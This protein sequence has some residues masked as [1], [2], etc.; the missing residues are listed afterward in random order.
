MR[1]QENTWCLTKRPFVDLNGKEFT[2]KDGPFLFTKFLSLNAIEIEYLDEKYQVQVQALEHFK[3]ALYIHD[4]EPYIIFKC[5]TG[6][7]AYGTNLPTSDKDF[8]GV[9][10]LP[11]DYIHAVDFDPDWEEVKV[12]NPKKNEET[13]YYEIRKLLRMLEEN[14][15]NTLEIFNL[16]PECIVYK[17]P[18]FDF[19]LNCEK[20]FITKQC[21]NRFLGYANE[22]IGKAR[23]QDKKQ[24][25]EKSR[26]ERKTVLDFCYTFAGAGTVPIKTW[27]QENKFKQEHCAL[28]KMEHMSFMYAVYYDWA[29]TL[30]YRGIVSNEETAN[31]V[32]EL[33]STPLGAEP[34]CYIQFN[35]NGYSHHCKEYKSYQTWIKER[36]TQRWV[37]VKS[38]D[39][40]IDGKNMLHCVRL[41][42]MA[43][44]IAEG[45]GI[46]VRRPEAEYLKS[47]RR[48]DV[49]LDDLI[50]W[51][52]DKLAALKDKFDKSDLPE[53]VGPYVS[54]VIYDHL[55]ENLE[56][57]TKS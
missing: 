56:W 14:N 11:P 41:I 32:S 4:I 51:S 23:G 30:G 52:S 33:S 46:V 10:V 7:N 5:V 31:G 37:D 45:R 27:I 44:D 9:Y 47:I 55:R 19:V 49:S 13:T 57:W 8:K 26:V 24:N 18:L 38:H 20:D 39:Q 2:K 16:P 1:L 40:K 54:Q 50:K 25:W 22:Q 21:Y 28:S 53:K 17:H 48:G 12:K 3:K 43:E 6:S 15:P 34:I 42:M 36:N 35:E 29:L